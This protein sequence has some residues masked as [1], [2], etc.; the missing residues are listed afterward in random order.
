MSSSPSPA[1]TRNLLSIEVDCPIPLAPKPRLWMILTRFELGRLTTATN[2]CVSAFSWR[3][4]E[5]GDVR[6]AKRSAAS[7][8]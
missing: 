2:N 3:N 5:D 6:K 7:C 1:S 8:F 4:K